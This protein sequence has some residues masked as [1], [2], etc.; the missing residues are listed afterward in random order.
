MFDVTTTTRIKIDHQLNDANSPAATAN[1]IDWSNPRFAELSAKLF[2]K[3]ASNQ[4]IGKAPTVMHFASPVRNPSSTSRLNASRRMKLHYS[5]A[6]FN[7]Q[8]IANHGDFDDVRMLNLVRHRFVVRTRLHD[9]RSDQA[10]VRTYQLA[11]TSPT[12]RF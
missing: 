7:I 4:E 9:F 6:Q 3:S 10:I 1:S 2:G 5:S 12:M 11:R 8:S